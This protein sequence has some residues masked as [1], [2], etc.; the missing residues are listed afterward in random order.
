[1]DF[2]IE[3][4]YIISHIRDVIFMNTVD[5]L[6]LIAIAAFDPII[7]EVINFIY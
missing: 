1:V 6:I 4:T 2:V 3:A 5:E 7:N